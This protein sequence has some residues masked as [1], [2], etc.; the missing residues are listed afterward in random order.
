MTI[1]SNVP[2]VAVI[3]AGG[4][5]KRMKNSGVPKQFLELYGKPIIVHTLEQFQQ[6]PAI[7]SIVVSCIKS[8]IENLGLL[9]QRYKLTKVKK[10]VAGGPTGQKSIFNALE[11]TEKLYSQC[12]KCIVLIHDGVRPLIDQET[13]T[14]NVKT[15]IESGSCITCVPVTET[16][17][18]KKINEGIEIPARE[19]S[20]LA[21]A[22]QSF[23]LSDILSAHRKA[24][25]DNID[26]FTDSCSLMSYYGYSM[27]MTEGKVENIK[28]TTPTDFFIFKAILDAKENSKI[29]GLL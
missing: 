15:V 25:R 22:P 3:F 28:I 8:H 17:F 5:G 24:I 26:D 21:R 12:E 7:D 13:I 1:D 9:V 20:F 16:V 10:I 19:N 6:H 14:K 11:A 2:V 18:L 23:F 27:S 4:S 29:F